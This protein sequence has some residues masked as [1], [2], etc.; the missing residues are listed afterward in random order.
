MGVVCR[1][2]SLG[3]ASMQCPHKTR[4]WESAIHQNPQERRGLPWGSGTQ[5][6]LLTA[7]ILPSHPTPT[8]PDPPIPAPLLSLVPLKCFDP[9]R[10]LHNSGG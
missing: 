4:A 1:A 9:P 5:Q 2:A 7:P 8:L 3:F 10:L 6:L